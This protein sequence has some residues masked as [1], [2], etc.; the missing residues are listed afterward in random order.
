MPNILASHVQAAEDFIEVL[1]VNQ[2]HRDQQ[3]S[4]VF[5]T[6]L[7][8]RPHGQPALD[9][10]I[11][12][13]PGGRWRNHSLEHE[14]KELRIDRHGRAQTFR[15]LLHQSRLARAEGTVD[16]DNHCSI[17]P[18]RRRPPHPRAMTVSRRA[19]SSGSRPHCRPA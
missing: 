4:T 12:K 9:R 10:Q 19:Y 8:E 5:P 15:E 13:V 11:L 2:G 16:P 7:L 18:G 1:R 14:S 3:R 6:N 17:L